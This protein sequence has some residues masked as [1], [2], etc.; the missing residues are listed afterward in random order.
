MERTL[1]AILAFY[2]QLNPIKQST[3]PGF[4]LVAAPD[5]AKDRTP[6]KRPK[7]TAHFPSYCFII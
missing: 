4:L 6:I 7:L 1:S 5:W 2:P 3:L